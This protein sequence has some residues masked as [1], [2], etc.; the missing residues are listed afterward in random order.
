[1]LSNRSA[2]SSP[3]SVLLV[4]VLSAVLVFVVVVQVRSQAAVERSLAGRDATTL[5]FLIDDL[6]SSNDALA[7]EV[8][9][10]QGQ[11][12]ALRHGG[13]SSASAEIAAEIKQLEVID[14]YAP[15][16]GPGVIISIEASLQAIDLQD[17]LN[18]LRMSGAEALTVN[19]RRVVTGTPIADHA[20]SVLVGGKA[21]GSPWTFVAVG[22]PQQLAG[23]ADLMTRTLQSDPRVKLATWRSDSELTISAVLTLRP[24]VY[25]TPG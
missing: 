5:A 21:E 25:G 6:H 15:A 13:G 3:V 9:R 10:S 19:G 24:Y 12:D 16:R 14:G 18:N 20:G 2:R 7:T 11:E 22:D 1:M 8:G 17:A 4:G 23:A